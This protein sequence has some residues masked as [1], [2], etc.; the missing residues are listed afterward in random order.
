MTRYKVKLSDG[1]TATI[2]EHELFDRKD[3][4]GL[5]S[6]EFVDFAYKG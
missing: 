3:V 5:I 4:A 1:T 6:I 2:W